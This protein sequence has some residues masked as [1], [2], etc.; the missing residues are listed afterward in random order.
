M[1]FENMIY[2]F[3]KTIQKKRKRVKGEKNE[4]EW[5]CVKNILCGGT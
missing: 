3:L 2:W 4:L 5:E 1:Y